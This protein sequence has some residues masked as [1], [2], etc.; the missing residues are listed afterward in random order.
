M[1]SEPEWWKVPSPRFWMKWG[2]SVKGARPSHWAP[3]PPI[4][5]MPTSWPRRSPPSR[6]TIVW[7]PMPM[8]TSSSG[9]ARVEE[10]C[11]QPEQK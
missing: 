11:G 8:P 4:W 5:G 3:S 2:S 1:A 6:A 7:Q 10:L 9:W